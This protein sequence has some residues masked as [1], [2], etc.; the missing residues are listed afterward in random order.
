MSQAR[1]GRPC[2]RTNSCEGLS[3]SFCV[4]LSTRFS[5]SRDLPRCE[6]K[7]HRGT[8]KKSKDMVLNKAKRTSVFIITCLLW[9][10]GEKTPSAYVTKLFQKHPW[11]PT[12]TVTH[13]HTRTPLSQPHSW[14]P[15]PLSASFSFSFSSLLSQSS[16]KVPGRGSKKI[17]R[18]PPF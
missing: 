5:L 8:K 4:I 2:Q 14:L 17:T 6:S 13:T 16:M 9:W 10:V 11:P 18:A 1:D 7:V 12:E 15:T 3:S